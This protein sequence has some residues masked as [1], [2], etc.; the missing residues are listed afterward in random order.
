MRVSKEAE[1]KPF[2]GEDHEYVV[3]GNSHIG[4][5]FSKETLELAA[6]VDISA[7]GRLLASGDGPLWQV[8]LAKDMDGDAIIPVASSN[9]TK[10]TYS[11]SRRARSV[12]LELMWTDASS[13]EERNII[14]ARARISA[15][16]GSP[17]LGW[18]IDVESNSKTRG[19]WYVD[20]PMLNSIMPMGTPEQTALFLPESTGV[21]INNP[22][23]KS[24]KYD[25]AGKLDATFWRWR[26]PSMQYSALYGST[27]G[28]FLSSHD[29]RAFNKSIH[30][31]NGTR[32]QTLAYY[33]RNTPENQG[34]MGISYRMPYE[35]VAT[36]F[37]GDWLTAAKLYR[38]WAIKQIWCSRGP[39]VNRKDVP[40]WFKEI[41]LWMLA[42]E[43][44][45][46]SRGKEYEEVYLPTIGPDKDQTL[47][48]IKTISARMGV[49][50]G[51]H[52]YGW[53][54]NWFD[55]DL[56]EYFPPKIGVEGF[57]KQVKAIHAMG[58]KVMPYINGYMWS[59]TMPSYRKENASQAAVKDRYGKI[60]GQGDI[61]DWMCPATKVWQNRM[62]DIS[63][64]L[65]R[66]YYADGVY[67]DQ[68]S[69]TLFSCFDSTHGHAMGANMFDGERK[70]LSRC[71]KSMHKSNPDTIMTGEMLSEVF[72]DCLDGL[73]L[74]MDQFRAGSVPAFQAVYHDY[75]I[76]FGNANLNYTESAVTVIPMLVGES[77]VAGDQ[78]GQ[79]NIWPIFTPDHPRQAVI[80]VYWKD[81]ETTRR[82]ADFVVQLVRLRY[83][84]GQKFLVYG[85]ML[86]PLVFD[87]KL[88]LV[89]G[90]WQKFADQ[91]EIKKFPAIMHSVWKA[92]DGT[93]GLVF[94]NIA[95]NEQKTSFTIDLR[96]YGVADK[97]AYRLIERASDGTERIVETHTTASFKTQITVPALKGLILE[98]RPE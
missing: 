15:G 45:G 77:F 88:P 19:L 1:G 16:A 57:Q 71:R 23:E 85:E 33:L 47:E 97:K 94:V 36:T 2:L 56:P 81:P 30:Y 96:D 60:V 14:Q 21:V 69:G 64:K 20:F 67:Y 4:A 34:A 92:P 18:S 17:Y 84:A 74:S 58:V 22:F 25:G 11:I 49:P 12:S 53:H 46:I 68:V 9:S 54:N 5:G 7:G 32:P 26:G 83:H 39:L 24:T 90:W 91:P 38:E 6:L 63:E 80:N 59:K 8:A 72:M 55:S 79:F 89:E 41:G 37:N 13:S 3:I 73:L 42:W 66:D 31:G 86:K 98:V 93:L 82:V 70:L 61:G 52:L 75:F 29:G 27:G 35:F 48:D 95:N 40:T 28:L 44:K 62:A 76:L 10:R 43:Q 65:V 51:V 50:I 78:L 87:D